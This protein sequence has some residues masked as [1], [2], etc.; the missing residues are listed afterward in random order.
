MKTSQLG[1]P[2][3]RC[4]GNEKPGNRPKTIEGKGLPASW[5]SSKIPHAGKPK[6]DQP[7]PRATEN[8]GALAAGDHSGVKEDQ[9]TYPSLIDPALKSWFDNVIVPSLVRNYLFEREES[10]R[11]PKSGKPSLAIVAEAIYA[12]HDSEQKQ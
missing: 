3:S 8:R 5:A 1:F 6:S 10:K 12:R 7:Q 4:L 11:P 2:V 9:R